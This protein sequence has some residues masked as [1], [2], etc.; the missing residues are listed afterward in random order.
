MLVYCIA[1]SNCKVVDNYVGKSIGATHFNY[2][3]TIN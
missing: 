3:K 2:T 1:K